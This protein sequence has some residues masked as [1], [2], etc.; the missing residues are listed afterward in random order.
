VV[1][2][3]GAGAYGWQRLTNH[4]PLKPSEIFRRSKRDRCDRG[5]EG[6]RESRLMWAWRKRERGRVGLWMAA[7]RRFENLGY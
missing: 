3:N 6:K 7:E 4:F 1:G 2:V 5:K